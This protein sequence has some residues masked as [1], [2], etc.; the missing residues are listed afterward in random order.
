MNTFSGVLFLH[1]ISKASAEGLDDL[2][3]GLQIR[4]KPHQ[5]Q[6][7]PLVVGSVRTVIEWSAV[8]D[9]APLLVSK[10]ADFG[11]IRFE[12]TLDH[13]KSQ[14]GR[15]WCF[16]PGLGIY[17]AAIDEAGNVLLAEN[18]IR[19]ALYGSGNDLLKTQAQLRKLLGTS[20]EDDLERFRAQSYEL[21][22]SWLIGLG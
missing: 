17:S 10:L 6:L 1:A 19:N 5:W 16:S 18:Q 8:D 21:E 15:R 7:Q 13:S 4:T 2:L 20:W 22:K 9:V 14:V 11:N 12:V 3:Q